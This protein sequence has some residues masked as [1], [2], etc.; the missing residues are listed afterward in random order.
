MVSRA[1]KLIIQTMNKIWCEQWLIFT[2]RVPSRSWILTITQHFPLHLRVIRG[3]LRQEN[4]PLAQVDGW[5]A[6]DFTALYGSIPQEDCIKQLSQSIYLAFEFEREKCK[7]RT[8][9]GADR[10]PFDSIVVPA[11]ADSRTP[12]R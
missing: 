2:N 10:R 1:L 12:A 6:E 9:N 8:G 3:I 7:M 5:K 11:I 4:S